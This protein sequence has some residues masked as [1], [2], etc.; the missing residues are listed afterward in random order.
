MQF[1][2]YR[3]PHG[4]VEWG[5]VAEGG[6]RSPYGEHALEDVELL[7][8]CTPSKVVCVGLNYRDHAEE[9]EMPLP[10]EPLLFLKPPTTVTGPDTDVILPPECTSLDYE[11]ELCVVM[12]RRARRIRPDQASAFI[13]GY[14]AGNDITARNFQTPGSQ[15]TRAKGFDT[16]APLGPILVRSLDPASLSIAS[17][18]N[19]E[20]RQKSNTDQMVL[21][22]PELVSFISSI[23]TLEPDDVIM[24]GTPSGIGSLKPGDEVEVE[25]EGIGVL[26]NTIVSEDGTAQ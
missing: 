9:I 21:G 20:S 23:M 19:G 4:A 3:T 18:V 8:P 7:A 12:A 11:A 1:A 13:A 25:I 10:D 6:V 5:E 14:T 15:W 26:R 2:R 16:F 17:R 22:V 24:T